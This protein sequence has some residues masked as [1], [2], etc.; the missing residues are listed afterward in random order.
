M[1]VAVAG[2]E[3][4]VRFGLDSGLRLRL[5]LGLEMALDLMVGL[6]LTFVLWCFWLGKHLTQARLMPALNLGL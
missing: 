3:V 5:E 1:T 6:R 4:A 2:P